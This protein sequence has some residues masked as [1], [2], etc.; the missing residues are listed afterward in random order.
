MIE[1]CGAGG[2]RVVVVEPYGTRQRAM[3]VLAQAHS[4]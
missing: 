3:A 2:H 4:G 1:S